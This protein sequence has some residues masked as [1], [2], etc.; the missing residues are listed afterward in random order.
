MASHIRAYR[1]EDISDILLYD[2]DSEI[3]A[4]LSYDWT[5]VLEDC[6]ISSGERVLEIGAGFGQL[7]YELLQFGAEVTVIEPS[8]F[9][10]RVLSDRFDNRNLDIYVGVPSEM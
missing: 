8:L 9:R 5:E 7:T 2:N 4:E 3:E 6:E 10:A 1:K